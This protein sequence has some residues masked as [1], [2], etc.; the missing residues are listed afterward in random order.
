M[1]STFTPP[2]TK[3]LPAFETARIAIEARP[4]A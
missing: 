3:S 1:Y 2:G 4:A